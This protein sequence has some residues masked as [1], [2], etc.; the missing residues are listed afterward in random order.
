MCEV[1]GVPLQT[2]V[3]IM[4]DLVLPVPGTQTHV[5]LDSWYMVK[6]VWKAARVSGFL[7]T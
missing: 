6:K 4:V 5:P 3:D 1:E 7:H 2:K